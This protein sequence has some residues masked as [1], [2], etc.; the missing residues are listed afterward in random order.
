MFACYFCCQGHY[1]V[2]SCGH[3]ATPTTPLATRQVAR[4]I[5]TLMDYAGIN[6]EELGT[7]SASP[8]SDDEEETRLSP[9]WEAILQEAR[10]EVARGDIL[11]PFTSA[12]EAIMAL[13]HES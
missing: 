8:A 2:I 12:E 11:G 1:G 6:I 7:L 10:D 3:M 13:H 4:S 9:E 5:R